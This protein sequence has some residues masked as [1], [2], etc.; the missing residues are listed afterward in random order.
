MHTYEKRMIWVD[1]MIA[2]R[3][4]CGVD[5]VRIINRRLPP[6]PGWPDDGL[7]LVRAWRRWRAQR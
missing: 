6:L 4:V 7:A 5:L 2:T 3:G 1:Q